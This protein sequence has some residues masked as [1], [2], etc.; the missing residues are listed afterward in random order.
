MVDSPPN[1][2]G[3]VG[4]AK[5]ARTKPPDPY[6]Q[7]AVARRVAIYTRVSREEQAA[8]HSLEAQER[9]CREF[10]A[11]EKPHWTLVAVCQ[12]THSGKTAERP[13]FE[14]LLRLIDNGQVDA[15][16][17]H[18][19]DRFSRNL[20]DILTYFREFKERNVIL[21]FAKDRFDFSTEEGQLQFRILAVFADW[22]LSNLAR[23]TRKGKQARV[24][25]GKHNN[26]LPFGYVKGPDGIGQLVPAEAAAI[27][28]AYEAYA[29]GNTTDAQLAAQFNK[30][31]LRTR[32]GRPWS[33]DSMRELL[34]NETYLG[35]VKYQGD[36]YPGKHPP[37]ISRELFDAVQRVREAHAR[38]PRLQTPTRQVY[39][40]S[41]LARCAHCQRTLRAQGGRSYS[42]Y[43]DMSKMRGFDDCPYSSRA[44]QQGVAEAQLGSLLTRLQLPADW[45]AELRAAL[46]ADDP[47][48]QQQATRERLERKLHHLGELYADEVYDR[49]TYDQERALVQEQLAQLV[50]PDPTASLEAG[51][52]LETLADV[53]PFATPEEQQQ[54]TRLL[55]KAVYIDL[56]EQRIVRVVPHEDFYPLLRY[57][58]D[59][60]PAPEGGYLVNARVATAGSRES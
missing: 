44:I 57:H 33:K 26:Q 27:H 60:T 21:T 23:E 22:Y 13:E 48:A 5:R 15:I 34:Q 25:K 20:H 17:T 55:F 9:E 41:G 12:E 59:L 16:L 43:R 58:P 30:Q 29:V 46:A 54:M 2:G 40:L 7:P 6:Q 31:G 35:M 32:R 8:G 56:A 3:P 10:L 14:R 4:R 1:A 50:I 45:Q 28:A 47:R 36:L 19:L 11:Q 42:Y 39:L 18:R 49:A 53:W 37:I 52:Q 38:R 24:L 51:F